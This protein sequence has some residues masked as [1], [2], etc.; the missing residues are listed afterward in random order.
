MVIRVLRARLALHVL[1]PG[2]LQPSRAMFVVS[3]V[4]AGEADTLGPTVLPMDSHW[5]LINYDSPDDGRA[6]RLGANPRGF[7]LS[8]PG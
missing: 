8:L 4:T 6:A 2:Q 3:P 1:Y 5:Q 7:G